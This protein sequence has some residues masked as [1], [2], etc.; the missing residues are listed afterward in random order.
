[1]P[2]TEPAKPTTAAAKHQ[3]VKATVTS[4]KP[5]A[6]SMVWFKNDGRQNFTPHV[7]AYQ[8]THLTTLDAADFDRDGRPTLVTGAFHAYPPYAA[9]SRVTLWHRAAGGAGFSPPSSAPPKKAD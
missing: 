6:V 3:S 4:G 1:M 9:M 8:P 5:T 2:T 7:L